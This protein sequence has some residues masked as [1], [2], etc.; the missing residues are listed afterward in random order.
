MS[1]QYTILSADT[2]SLLIEMVN[3]YLEQGWICRGG[4]AIQ[5]EPIQERMRPVTE[6]HQAMTKYEKE[7]LDSAYAD[8]HDESRPQPR[9]HFD[10]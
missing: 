6:F 3:S 7:P 9:G 2:P 1:T 10:F 5:V 4:L 8:E